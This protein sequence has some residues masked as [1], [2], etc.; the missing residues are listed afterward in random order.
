MKAD[1]VFFDPDSVRATATYEEPRS[2]PIGIDWVIVNGEVVVAEGL[3]T[4]ATPGRV[5]RRGSAG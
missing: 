4:G 1:V 2:F 3:H 5:L